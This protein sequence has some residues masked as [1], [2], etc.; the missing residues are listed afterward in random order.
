MLASRTSRWSL[1]T[2]LLCVVLLAASWF[3][4]IGPRR[5][6]AADVHDQAMQANDRAQ[7]L[8]QE[9][10][11]LKS[12]YAGLSKKKAELKAI[13]AQLPPDADVPSLVRT[14]QDYAGRAGVS[15]D[16]ITPGAPVV[17]APDGS[18]AA[19][20]SATAGS[21]V[22]LPLAIAITGQYF[23]N[24]LFVKYLQTQLT[25]SFLISGL[26]TTAS[27]G[28][29]TTG[30]ATAAPTPAPTPTPTPTS[31]A[32]ADRSMNISGAVFVL[33][34][35]SSTLAQIAAEAKKAATG[36]ATTGAAATTTTAGGSPSTTR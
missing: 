22:S 32:G 11:Q 23:E 13:K 27:S 24:S 7:V 4:L 36:T 29:G 31:T 9:L 14:L 21:V 5:V 35:G 20:A 28:A 6:E 30:T 1:G 16:S 19:N 18:V 33:L 26:T 25:R 12:D 17:L 10:V 2:A 3:L 34:D 8:Q 15:I